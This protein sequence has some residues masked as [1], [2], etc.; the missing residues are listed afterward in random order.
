MTDNPDAVIEFRRPDGQILAYADYGDPHGFPVLV[1]HGLI[2]SIGD[3]G[4]FRRLTAHGRRV[5]CLARPGYGRSTP[6]AL[7]NLAAWARW[8]HPLLDYLQL[9]SFDLLGLSSGAPYAYALAWGCAQ[10]ARAV[11][12]FSGMPALDDPAVRAAWPYPLTPEADLPELQALARE[13]FFSGIAPGD[14]V[15]ADVR[16]AMANDCFG[17]AL[18]LQ[19]RARPWGF[20]LAEVRQPVRLS[21]CRTDDSVPFRTAELSAALL[22]NARLEI[23]T[24]GHFSAA[25]LDDF[26][27]GML[28]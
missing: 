5:I 22:P 27:A 12:I 10:Q 24:G 2:A 8:V 4:L 19:L 1:Q 18:D 7:P 15:S 6:A 13:L 9:E 11:H 14:P 3:G 20:S 23:H 25:L 17:V 21:H 28:G 26:L 16:D